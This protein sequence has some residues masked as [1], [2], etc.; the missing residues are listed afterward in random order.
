M[1]ISKLIGCALLVTAFGCKGEIGVS[2]DDPEVFETAGQQSAQPTS[3]QPTSDQPAA[4][5]V[6]PTPGETPVETPDESPSPR[7]VPALQLAEL[8][9]EE[10]TF[11]M[12]SISQML[13]AR[14]LSLE[15]IQQIER[16][17]HEAMRP[18]LE[19]WVAEPAFATSATYMMQQ[20]LKASGDRDEIDFEAPGRIVEHTV[21]N[22]LP[23][24]TVVTA[25]YCIAPDGSQTDCDSGA[26][27][28]AGV[29]TTRAFLSGNASRFNLGRA[30]RMMKVFAC[31]GYPM[32]DT[33]QPYL[34]K[35]DLIPMFRALLPE[36]Q[37]VEEAR[38]AFGN[39]SACYTC[40]GQFS[41]HSQF[42]VKFDEDGRWIEDA[43]GL[44]DPEGEL[45][46]SFGGL[47]TSHMVEPREAAY[48]G[49]KM[50]G[51]DAANL[52]EA[53]QILTESDAFVPCMVRNMLE[54]TFGMTD[55][56]AADIESRLLRD[57]AER[58][59]LAGAA[60]PTLDEI[61]V[62]T[63]TDPRV[64]EVVLESRGAAQ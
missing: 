6:T 26:P 34:P 58:L 20:K 42:Y 2:A 24:S 56:A 44:Q 43:T 52:S 53:A 27:Y 13:I 8:S 5:T 57:I 63:F 48:E 35:E 45:G 64:V 10:V 7:E 54:Y 32:E 29:F 41:A 25:D 59:R 61:V 22:D 55:S 23:F 1:K 49:S 11:F 33:L 51:R 50:F 62:E 14:P 3:D 40:H 28:N 37:T 19:N 46:R 15:E 39:G 17:G 12:R 31:R 16:T 47:M 36:E 9:P 38:D 4:P 30:S 18:M 60:D 21:A